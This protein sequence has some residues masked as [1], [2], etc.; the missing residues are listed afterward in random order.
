MITVY[1]KPGCTL[2]EQAKA[3]SQTRGLEYQYI[4]I[5]IGQRKNLNEEYISRDKFMMLFPEARTVPQILVDDLHVGG[6]REFQEY[7]KGQTL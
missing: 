2:C 6:I 4:E 3:L 1:G 7:L 5:D